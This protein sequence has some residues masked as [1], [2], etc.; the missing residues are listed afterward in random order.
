MDDSV[1]TCNE[2]IRTGKTKKVKINVN[3]KIQSI[4]QT[5]SIVYLPFY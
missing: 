3:K 4:K 5:I 1:I 2:I